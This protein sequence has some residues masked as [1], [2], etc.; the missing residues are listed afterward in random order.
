MA[1]HQMVLL[2]YEQGR[3]SRV[4]VAWL[5]GRVVRLPIYRRRVPREL[6]ITFGSEGP[7]S[8]D[9][10]TVWDESWA[11]NEAEFLEACGEAATAVVE[12][13]MYMLERDPPPFPGED[14]EAEWWDDESKRLAPVLEIIRAE[15][16]ATYGRIVDVASAHSGMGSTMNSAFFPPAS[17]RAN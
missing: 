11:I 16:N 6:S 7:A 8:G 9:V 2:G 4:G 13:M 17:R 12:V 10:V 1:H 3:E 5:N 14:G 15:P